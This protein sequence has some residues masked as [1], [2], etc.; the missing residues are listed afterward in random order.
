MMVKGSERTALITGESTVSYNELLRQI[1][2]YAGLY[3][4]RKGDRVA[5][6]SENRPEWI[7]A[8]YSAWANGGVSVPIDFMSPSVDVR[9]LLEDSTPAVVFTSHAC[10][11]VLRSAL[12]NLRRKPRIFIFEEIRPAAP[13]R[14]SELRIE[15]PDAIAAI[16]YTSGTTGNAKGVML[17]FDNLLASIEAITGL[18]M[19]T[20]DDRM[21]AILPF[22]H[23]FPLQGTVT[24]PLYMG[25]TIV[26]SRSLNPDD[27]LATLQKHRITMFLGVPRLYEAFHAS[28]MAKI[29]SNPVARVLFITSR[30]IGSLS[31]SRLLFKKVQDAFGGS[32]HAYLTGGAPMRPEV[33]RDLRALG[34]KLIE[35]YGLTETAPLVSFNRFDRI[36]PGSVGQPVPN[37]EVRIIDGEIAVRG[38][39][40]MK[41]YYKKPTATTRALRDGWFFTG[42]AGSIDEEGFITISGR[43]DEMIVLASGKNI[44]PD[45]IETRLKS[46][47]PLV[48]DAA[49]TL[50]N[51]QLTALI[52]PNMS[53]ARKNGV[54][55][56]QEMIKWKAI[57]VYNASVQPYRRILNIALTNR[58]LPRTR[59]G[60]LRR[61]LLE[62]YFTTDPRSSNSVPEPEFEEYR[63]LKRFLRDIT[64]SAVHP[65]DHFEMDLGL[66]SLNRVE[67]IAYCETVFGLKLSE[68]DLAANHNPRKLAEILRL[69]KTKLSSEELVN[70]EVILAEG[71]QVRLPEPKMLA[72]TIIRGLLRPVARLMFRL[73][74]QGMEMIP[75]SPLII[76]PNHQSY[77]DAFLVMLVMPRRMLKT[78][79]FIANSKHFITR[80]VGMLSRN[81]II[82][83][84][85][86]DLK[87]A[88][89]T[90]AAALKNGKNVVIFPEGTR[91]RDGRLGV[92]KKTFA[93]LS[94]ELNVPVV[95]LA[96]S[97]AY[98]SFPFG[99]LLPRPGN[100]ELRFAEPI[101]PGRGDYQAIID[102]VRSVI[103]ALLPEK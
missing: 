22:H 53:L 1:G 89:S 21:L 52:N 13:V 84:I 40:V 50:R 18:G 75:D 85:E 43:V 67:L 37:T 74:H 12:K 42:D 6:F 44:N 81:I 87:T 76:T 62:D 73:K 5:V 38:R 80:L 48:A 28:L 60:K 4:I 46:L 9:A 25:A 49:I 36:K 56:I 61:H 69:R 63:L 10:L 15:D 47:T 82:L 66:D 70:W 68:M 99:R 83:N 103:D 30:G 57:D 20:A 2:I 65:E 100:I 11:T 31:L 55:N 101:Y 59:L 23:I 91:S 7:Y 34:F 98:E 78:T 77:L 97:G 17:T 102:R 39:N 54:G 32:I 93:I 86:K 72:P 24:C 92:F 58:D 51:G 71:E 14:F 79:F 26:F 16:L 8:F 33:E 3:R 19:L 41:G 88:L 35:G 96:I 29:R 95:P 45:E 94:K 64:G 27:I 90:T